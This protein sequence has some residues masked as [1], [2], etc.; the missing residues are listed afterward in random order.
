MCAI[1]YVLIV[2]DAFF[3][4]MNARLPNAAASVDA[5]GLGIIKAFKSKAR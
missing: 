3:R 1:A 5:I 2:R 4:A